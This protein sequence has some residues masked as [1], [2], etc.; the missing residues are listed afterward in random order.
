[1]LDGIYEK[2]S[3]QNPQLWLTLKIEWTNAWIPVVACSLARTSID[4]ATRRFAS[5][6]SVWDF[7]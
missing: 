6:W 1:M 3:N 4:A 7:T 5:S 2:S